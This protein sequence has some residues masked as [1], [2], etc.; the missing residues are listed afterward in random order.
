MLDFDIIY[1]LKKLN[2]CKKLTNNDL[3]SKNVNDFNF[4]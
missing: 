4:T 3:W 2:L 1:I